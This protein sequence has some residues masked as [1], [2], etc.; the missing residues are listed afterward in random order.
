MA[1][2]FADTSFW[3]ALIDRRDAYHATAIVWSRKISGGLTTTQAVL[4]ET[5]NTFARPVWRDKAIALIDHLRVRE[6]VEIVTL[7]ESLWES[8]WNLF[9]HR[10][11]KAWS[12]TDC[13][14][15]EVMRERQLRNALAT[16]SHF[17]QAGFTA[18]LLDPE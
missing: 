17:Q 13:M 8:A 9:V 14:S 3:I 1:D 18:L 12:L 16:D 10:S 6:D 15:F 11:D 7:S 5:A 2:Y 4:L